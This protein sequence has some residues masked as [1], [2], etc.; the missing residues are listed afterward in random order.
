MI[1]VQWLK[2]TLNFKFTV[3]TS[4]GS[5]SKKDTYFIVISSPDGVYGIGECGLL[6]GLSLDDQPGFEHK[7]NEIIRTSSNNPLEN[8]E[9]LPGYLDQMTGKSMP[10]IKMGLETAWLDYLNGGNRVIFN[11]PF[12]EGRPIPI[13]GLIWMGNKEKMLERIRK[14][15]A[16]DFTCI[17]IKIGA[18]DFEDEL[19]LIE[20]IRNYTDDHQV[21][22]RVDANG[23]FS[24]EEAMHKLEKLAVYDIHSIEQP[25]PT[26]RWKEMAEL[27]R[28]SPVP[29]ALDEELIGPLNRDQKAALLDTIQ[30]RYI[31]LKPTLL[32][33]FH[34]T[35]EWIELGESKNTG[36][37]ITSALESNIGLNAIAQYTGQKEIQME[38][39]LGTGQLY[40]NNIPSP[41]EIKNGSLIYDK[42]IK[43]DLTS[44]GID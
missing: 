17:K 4:R 39:G 42:T 28:K 1:Q 37:W 19:N 12:L 9:H 33:G 44:L 25:I 5:M 41:L 15:A 30:P 35:E 20:Y 8:I 21:T 31:V 27:C 13:N 29:V 32:G 40:T 11:S 16:E 36:W 10:S 7:M 38:Q 6:P 14:K 22:I 18:I 2:Y 34:E 26:G 24:I 43:W 3:T 23:A